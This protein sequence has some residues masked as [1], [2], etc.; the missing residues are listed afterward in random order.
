MKTWLLL[1]TIAFESSGIYIITTQNMTLSMWLAFA[2][3]HAMSCLSFSAL[4]W[5]I[6]PKKYKT[7]VISSFSFLFIFNYLLP[8]VGMIGTSCSLLIAL[9]LPREKSN[10]TWQECE[11]SELPQNPGD[12]INTQFGI[13]AL[14]EILLHNQDPDRRLLAVSAIRN[15]PRQQAVPLLQLALKDLTD[16][17]RLLAYASLE[18]IETQIN[19]TISLSKKQFEY[20]PSAAKASDIAQQYWELCYLGIAEGILRNHYLE[21]AENYLNQSNSIKPSA[22][23]NLLL[24]RVLLERQRPAEAVPVLKAAMDE[25]IL[26]KQ[27]APYLAEAS[28]ITGD[29]QTAREYIAYFPEQKGNKLSQIKEYWG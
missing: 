27:V 23:A 20:Q 2:S 15:L 10:I 19:E 11:K 28:Y 3:V 8:V 26:F 13:G 21:Q 16:D 12:V 17:V 5:L 14:R 4:C 24:G 29:F 7:P 25:G 9:Y 18:N 22:S 6:L 1:Q